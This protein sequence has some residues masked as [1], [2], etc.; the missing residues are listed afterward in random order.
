MQ[1]VTSVGLNSVSKFFEVQME[2]AGILAGTDYSSVQ[3][4][5]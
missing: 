1:E 3:E 5:K 2:L 4:L